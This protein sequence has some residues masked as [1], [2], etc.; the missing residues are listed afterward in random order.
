MIGLEQRPKLDKTTELQLVQLF[1]A[2]IARVRKP[3]PLGTKDIV[4][5]PDG[6]VRPGDARLNQLASTIAAAAKAGAQVKITT[7][8]FR[9]KS[10]YIEATAVP[11]PKPKW[12]DHITLALTASTVAAHP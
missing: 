6:L 3:L 9:E 10:A 8:V 1:N 12:H 2:E 11:T 5:T 4:V 7:T